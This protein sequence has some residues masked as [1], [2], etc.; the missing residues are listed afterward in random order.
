MDTRCQL[1]T[2]WYQASRRQEPAPGLLVYFDRG[3]QYASAEHAQLLQRHGLTPSKPQ[4]NPFILSA[5]RR[6]AKRAER[7]MQKEGLFQR[8]SS[9]F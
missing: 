8:S 7:S 9:C 2:W 6:N 5:D 4:R 1:L 3:G